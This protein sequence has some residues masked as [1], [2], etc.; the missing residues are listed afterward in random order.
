MERKALSKARQR[1]SALMRA[2]ISVSSAR[3][4]RARRAR[5]SSKDAS[6]VGSL[7][8]RRWFVWAVLRLV[9]WLKR[10]TSAFSRSWVSSAGRLGL[11]FLTS[12][13]QAIIAASMRSVFSRTPIASAKRRTSRGLRIAQGRSCAHRRAKG[14]FSYPPVASIAT[15]PTPWLWQNAASA[16]TPSAVLAKR[17]KAPARPMRASRCVD[18]TSTPQMMSV[19]VT[20]LVRATAHRATVRSCVTKATVPKLIRGCSRRGNGRPPPREGTGG[21]P[22]PR[23]PATLTPPGD[24]PDTRGRAAVALFRLHFPT[25]AYRGR[26]TYDLHSLGRAP[27]GATPHPAALARSPFSPRVPQGEK[28]G[29]RRPRCVN[30]VAHKARGRSSPLFCAPKRAMR[31]SA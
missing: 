9:S 2:A 7:T 8:R 28:G 23:S 3:I 17:W 13:H 5:I 24:S 16:A 21:R 31:S 29:A 6:A 15:R 22:P 12:A 4:W 19:T 11:T 30:A 26:Y 27:R 20:C 14:L 18:E 1:G 25:A 10:K